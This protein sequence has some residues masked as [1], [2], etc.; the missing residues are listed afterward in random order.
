MLYRYLLNPLVHNF[1]K[2]YGVSELNGREIKKGKNM[3]KS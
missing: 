2:F 3:F 1:Y